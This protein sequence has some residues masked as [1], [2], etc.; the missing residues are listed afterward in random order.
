MVIM[1]SI[2]VFCAGSHPGLQ[3][4]MTVEHL[5]E[6]Y[7][8]P[9]DRFTDDGYYYRY[10][11]DEDRKRRD[12]DAALQGDGSNEEGNGLDFVDIGETKF[13]IAHDSSIYG[14]Y[15]KHNVRHDKDLRQINDDD[16]GHYKDNESID[17]RNEKDKR[18]MNIVPDNE[19]RNIDYRHDK[20]KVKFKDVYDLNIQNVDNKERKESGPYTA[21]FANE[22]E[23]F[24][25]H[26]K[27]RIHFDAKKLREGKYVDKKDDAKE[28]HFRGRRSTPDNGEDDGDMDYSGESEEMTRDDDEHHM[29]PKGQ[30]T[31]IDVELSPPHPI[32]YGIDT[33]CVLFFTLELIC[34]FTF[35][36][37]KLKFFIS[38][39]NIIDVVALLPFYIELIMNHVDTTEKYQH[40][41]IDVLFLLQ[42]LRILRVFRL[43][44]HVKGLRVLMYTVRYGWREMILMLLF[45]LI[46]MLLF[47]SLIFYTDYSKGQ[48]QS[49]PH[50]FWW[51][52]ITMTTVGYGDVVPQTSWGYAVGSLCAFT[53]VLVIAFSVPSL[54]NNFMLFYSHVQY[55]K[56]PRCS[57]NHTLRQN[58]TDCK[59]D[60]NTEQLIT[61]VKS[62]KI[63]VKQLSS[64][65]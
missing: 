54:V 9:K 36:P 56:A 63:P 48:F 24:M 18:K 34:R 33:V 15:R 19:K 65:N 29:A 14:I 50:A 46:G 55:E 44:R 30:K 39:M 8:A 40:S 10:D 51:A 38:P 11:D 21:E 25:G 41:A 59:G 6:F 26:N 35:S 42:V 49:I 17:L 60:K 57:K 52:I 7:D 5:A 16:V 45:L 13:G 31:K 3:Q 43:I 4:D 64:I 47:G 32:L 23:N 62:L 22:P 2:T 37:S 12:V 1:T 27:Y 58:S 28:I 61:N 20:D 53:G